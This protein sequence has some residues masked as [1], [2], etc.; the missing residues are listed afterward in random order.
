[1]LA[2]PRKASIETL[3][4]VV[5]FGL[6]GLALSLYLLQLLPTSMVDAAVLLAGMG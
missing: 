6:G 3:T 5:L 1:M 4:V 2:G